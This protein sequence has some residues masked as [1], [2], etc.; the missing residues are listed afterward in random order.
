MQHNGVVLALMLAW[1]VPCS[2]T[3]HEPR[4]ATGAEPFDRTD[5]LAVSQAAIGRRVRDLAFTGSDGRSHTLAGYAGTPLVV[6]LVYTS[7][8]HICPTTT[9]NL[10]RV[11]R[12]ARTLLGNDSFAVLTVGF[13]S[14][15]DT[16]D[17]M[18][19]F[20]RE[21]QVDDPNWDFVAA[22]AETAAALASDLGFRFRASA[23]GFDHLLQTTLIDADGIVRRHVYGADIDAPLLVDPLKR[24]VYGE[25]LG[26]SLL[27]RIGNRFRLYCTV[28]DP[29]SDSYRF[30]YSI[31]VGIAMGAAMGLYFIVLLLREWRRSSRAEPRMP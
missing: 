24:L 28:Y 1:A 7:C 11:V 29:A 3:V 12:N 17:A 8:Y 26:D 18:R 2:A 6:S 5:T 23:G 14:T 22:D 20:A 13:D 25:Q 15:R 21:Q 30:S 19:R 31:L 27:E 16:P 9:R 4:P 10:A